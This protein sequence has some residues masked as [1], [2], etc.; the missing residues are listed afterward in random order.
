MDIP[1]L[2]NQIEK[3]KYENAMNN[4]PIYERVVI[5]NVI[6]K[7]REDEWLGNFSNEREIERKKRDR[8]R[9]RRNIDTEKERDIEI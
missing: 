5:K 4:L 1:Q 8:E 3:E 9:Q 2:H 7:I 6:H